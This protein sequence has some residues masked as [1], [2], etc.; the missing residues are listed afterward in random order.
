[1]CIYLCFC[2]SQP[3]VHYTDRIRITFPLSVLFW[4]VQLTDRKF[5][6][7]LMK[8]GTFGKFFNPKTNT[9]KN[10][11]DGSLFS[12]TSLLFRS[13]LK[14]FIWITEGSY[15]IFNGGPWSAIV[16]SLVFIYEI[17]VKWTKTYSISDVSK[18]CITNYILETKMSVIFYGCWMEYR[19]QHSTSIKNVFDV[20]YILLV[21][22]CLW[23]QVNNN[24]FVFPV[25]H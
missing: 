24:S 1:M 23:S 12:I 19:H 7:I 16:F 9:I 11:S 3:S 18:L 6:N 20:L 10:G 21:H 13:L 5:E 15:R 2:L 14:M 22:M 25:S 17:P 4:C 8:S